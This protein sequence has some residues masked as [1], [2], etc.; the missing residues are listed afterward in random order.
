MNSQLRKQDKGT[1]VFFFDVDKLTNVS[2]SDSRGFEISC[3]HVWHNSEGENVGE[4]TWALRGNEVYEL[5][6]MP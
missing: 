4:L 2:E 1:Q 6:L 3:S 5:S